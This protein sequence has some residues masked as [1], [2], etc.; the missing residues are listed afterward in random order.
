[1]VKTDSNVSFSERNIC[2]SFLCTFKFSVSYLTVSFRFINL[3]FK[4]AVLSS[5]DWFG[6]I[7]ITDRPVYWNPLLYYKETNLSYI[8]IILKESYIF[9]KKLDLNFYKLDNYMLRLFQLF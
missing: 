2:T 8:S 6:S 3:P 1:M 7:P 9:Y 4:W 5:P